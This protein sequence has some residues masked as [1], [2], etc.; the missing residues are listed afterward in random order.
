[1]VCWTMAKSS[2]W[3]VPVTLCRQ[4][5]W[6]TTAR[7]EVGFNDCGNGILLAQG[8]C[9]ASAAFPY[10]VLFKIRK[11]LKAPAAELARTG[12][13][14][15]NTNESGWIC[16]TITTAWKAPNAVVVALEGNAHLF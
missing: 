3:G 4:G 5:C 8:Y 9:G 15:A 14:A 1:M 16:P 10:G 2:G 6:S 13:R 11:D 12:G 7:A